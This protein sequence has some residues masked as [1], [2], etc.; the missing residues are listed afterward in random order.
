MRV[1]LDTT[2]LVSAFTTRGLSADVFRLVIS[3]HELLT[4]EVNL[5]ELRRVLRRKM[6]VPSAR[7]EEIERLV[8]E[9]TIIPRPSKPHDEP[10]RDADDKWVLA[11]AVAGQADVLVTGDNDLLELGARAPLPVLN[12]RSL[13]ESLRRTR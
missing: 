11:S 2:V 3:E 7:L 9:H 8:R 5:A 10:A 12:P 4:G 6:R 13:W 1:L